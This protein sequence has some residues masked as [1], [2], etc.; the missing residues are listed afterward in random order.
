[1]PQKYVSAADVATFVHHRGATT[2]PGAPPDTSR[3]RVVLCL[4]DAGGNGNVFAGVLDG[5]AGHHSPLAFDQPGHGRSGGLDSLGAIE[6]MAAHARAVADQLQLASPVLLGDGLGAA[7]ALEAAIAEPSWP[8]ALVLC[9]GATA[10]FTL[11]PG[12]VDA[13]RKVATGKARREFDRTCL[14]YTSDAADE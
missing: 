14:L 12:T 9:G 7:V 3:G 4:H 2:L 11:A 5:L 13:V 6:R 8:A 1:M 10:R